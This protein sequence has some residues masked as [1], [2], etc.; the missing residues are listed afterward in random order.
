ML[1]I[2]SYFKTLIKL[3]TYQLTYIKY[4]FYSIIVYLQIVNTIV[5]ND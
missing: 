3:K 2:E 4:T 5:H 1:D